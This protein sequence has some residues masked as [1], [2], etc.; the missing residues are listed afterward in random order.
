[1]PEQASTIRLITQPIYVTL[2][3][4]HH[5]MPDTRLD[6]PTYAN[7]V[8]ALVLPT[9]DMVD[10]PDHLA[11]SIGLPVEERRTES[12]TMPNPKAIRLVKLFQRLRPGHALECHDLVT[13]LE[14]WEYDKGS[15]LTQ[16]A[17]QPVNHV[18]QYEEVKSGNPY[19]VL[20]PRGSDSDPD[21]GRSH[22]CIG[23]DQGRLLG[24]MGRGLALATMSPQSTRQ[25]YANGAELSY[26]AK[27]VL[28][29]ERP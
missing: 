16:R 6:M 23:T 21:Y 27:T 4:Q 10:N 17:V 28:P 14:G 2:N 8:E 9:G 12:I 5:S 22:S 24:L 7:V 26:L 13:Q 3:V 25:V 19:T 18:E 1:M 11:I 15:E 20:I 29:E